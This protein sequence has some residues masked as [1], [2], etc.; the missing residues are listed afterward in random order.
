MV[1]VFFSR[2]SLEEN[3]READNMSVLIPVSE[4]LQ[5]AQPAGSVVSKVRKPLRL[6]CRVSLV[7]VH[8]R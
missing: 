1:F 5:G 4:Q 3:W 2:S 6:A 7:D 8:G